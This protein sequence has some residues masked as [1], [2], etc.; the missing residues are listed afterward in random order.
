MN[1]EPETPLKKA[2]NC[3]LT[4]LFST[5][6]EAEVACTNGPARSPPLYHAS[7][8]LAKLGNL[9]SKFS[10]PHLTAYVSRFETMRRSHIC[11]NE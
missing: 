5:T 7:R 10:A 2:G 11:L 4:L 8:V 6:K 9:F 3:E 1:I